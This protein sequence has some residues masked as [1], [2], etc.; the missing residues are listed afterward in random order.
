MPVIRLKWLSGFYKYKHEH[1]HAILGLRH[2]NRH[3][4]DWVFPSDSASGHL[5]DPKNGWAALVKR[6]KIKDL[7]MHDLRRSLGSYM[8]MAGASLSVIGNALNHREVSTTRKVYAHSAQEAERKVQILT[9][10]GR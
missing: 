9:Q 6:A 7:H 3:S 4:F 5:L 10:N 2:A 8:A 1:E